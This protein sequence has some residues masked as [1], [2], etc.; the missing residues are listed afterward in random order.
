MQLIGNGL[1][2][3]GQTD[4]YEEYDLKT[5]ASMH[6]FKGIGTQSAYR[7]AN[8]DTMLSTTAGGITLVILEA[9][10]DAVKTKIVYGGYNYVRLVRPT[11][12]GTF[13]VPTDTTLFEG[14]DQGKILWHVTAPGWQHIWEALEM[15]NG[16]VVVGTS[17]GSSLDILDAN[18]MVIQRIGTKQMPDAATIRPNFFS[19]FQILPN[20][21]FVT[22]NW[23]GHGGGNGASGVQVLEFDPT[24]KLVWS[25][26]Q[27]ATVYSSI[28]A[29]MVLDGLDPQY[30]HT[31]A[32][33][34]QWTP[35]K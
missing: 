24:G 2:L 21:N 4:G 22:P 18:H 16:H 15:P 20:G 9:K 13:L 10:T 1:I 29:V 3:G 35:V 8:G 26:K 25:Y 12:R 17:V 11:P 5:G 19:E 34:G 31:E 23:Q 14:D 7:L 27:D 30:L 33:T 32:V 6:R 28:Q